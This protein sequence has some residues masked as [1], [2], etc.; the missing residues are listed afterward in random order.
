MKHIVCESI[1]EAANVIEELES[2]G[3][4]IYHA[5]STYKEK[6]V[7]TGEFN[8]IGNPKYEYRTQENALA[9]KA[10]W[11]DIDVG[12]IN[13]KTG[14]PVGHQSR[15]A[16]LAALDV[17]IEAYAL[18][19]PLIVNSGNGYHV[20]W[21]LTSAIPK[22]QWTKFAAIFNEMAVRVRLQHD[23]SCTID[24]ARVLR[25]VGST[26]RKHSKA[27]PVE[28]VSEVPELIDTT[29]FA[30]KLVTWAKEQ[31]FVPIVPDASLFRND[32]AYTPDYPPSSAYEIVKH[33]QQ[34]KAVVDVRS[35]VEE[36]LWYAM[37]NLVSCTVEGDALCHEWSMGDER[38]SYD[39]TQKKIDQWRGK[40]T[41]C[42][43]WEILNP[44][45]CN[46]CAHKGKIKNPIHLG[47]IM[48]E[49][50]AAPQADAESI[51]YENAEAAEPEPVKFPADVAYSFVWDGSRLVRRVSG[52]EDSSGIAQV[53]AF[54]E[55]LFMPT[56]YFRDP[57]T[58]HYRVIWSATEPTGRVRE[59]ELSGAAMGVGGMTLA[60]ELGEQG[61]VAISGQKKHMEAY[62]TTWFNSLRKRTEEVNVFYQYGWQKDWSFILGQ[63]QYMPNGDVRRVRLSGNAAIPTYIEAFEPQGT[64]EEWVELVD[65][66]YNYEGQEQYQFTL[67]IGFGAPLIRLFENYGGLIVNGYS[68]NKGLG[69]ST[70]GKLALGIYGDPKVLVRTKQQTTTK[71]FNAHCGVMNSLPVMLDE[72]TNVEPKALSE[73]AYTFSQGTP[74]QGLNPDGS[75]RTTLHSWSTIMIANANRSLINVVGAG[76]ANADAEMG[77][78]LEYE[79]VRVSKLTKEEAD[80]VLARSESIYG[81][82]GRQYISY[83]V[84]NRE[85]VL[86]LLRKAQKVLDKRIGASVS[87]RFHSIGVAAV[88]VGLT[89]AKRLGLI[90]FDLTSLT[91]WIVMRT[92]TLQDRIQD[93]L[94]PMSSVFGLM[95]SEL[96]AGVIVTSIE[97]DSRANGKAAIVLTHP[98]GAVTGRLIQE[99]GT[100]YLQQGLI[101]QWCAKNQADYGAMWA[102]VVNNGWAAP[103]IVSYSLGKGTKDYALPPTRCWKIDASKMD[104]D[105]AADVRD[106]IYAIK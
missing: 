40:P 51:E 38:Y 1:E 66:V 16:A 22:K 89:I 31:S 43:R 98:R 96:A 102:E 72:A 5:C 92:R 3:N 58:G 100:L 52:E 27:Q 84:T 53:K 32:L 14:E 94:P 50:G 55:I 46:G 56:N 63:Y 4:T 69:K 12:K 75:M 6:Q 18:P 2:Q 19:K 61:I 28:V 15:E 39:E 106:K 70:A 79:I 59:F 85:Q 45:G 17:F 105:E 93:N 91:D 24:S 60:K 7:E 82:V 21:G 64:A 23:T 87:D 76:K 44:G 48:P 29:G 30:T 26:N 86:E 47:Q 54:C 9:A 71:A 65:R 41:T 49:A 80:D 36:P 81:E 73:I 62:V 20:Y 42:A 104:G 8:S 97:G 35:D 34:L 11:V 103:D 99:S 78:I 74:G 68:P 90:N 95:V 33:C 83:L 10:F 88:V 37:V 67:G 77:R 57:R 25:P 13:K 101:R